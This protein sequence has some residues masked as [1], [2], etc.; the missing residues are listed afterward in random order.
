MGER[1]TDRVLVHEPEELYDIEADPMEST[2][3]I[4]DPALAGVEAEMRDKLLAFRRA[5]KDP[6]LEVDYQE[7]RPDE[8]PP[9]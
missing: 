2:N 9:V 3:L 8:H 1:D 5:T 7:G 4:G 6:W